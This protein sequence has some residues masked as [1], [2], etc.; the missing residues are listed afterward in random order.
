[1]GHEPRP[2]H[3][4]HLEGRREVTEYTS[5]PTVKIIENA[6]LDGVRPGDHLVWEH[7][8]EVDGVTTTVRREGVA[9]RRDEHGTWWTK[10]GMWITTGEVKD[11]T[12][13]IRRTVQ[14]LST[15]FEA[16]IVAHDKDADI[17]AVV[18]GETWRTREAI[19]GRNGCWYPLWRLGVRARLSVLPEAIT[20]N[21]WKV[22]EK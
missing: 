4:R 14:D 11:T 15:D 3:P 7:T 13:T 2:H 10:D 5:D 22:E 16:T 20:P 18:D 12:L 1:M 21:T 9:H 8:R 19:R 6:R 17:E